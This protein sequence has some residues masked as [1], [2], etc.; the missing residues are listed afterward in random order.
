LDELLVLGNVRKEDFESDDA[1]VVA[2]LLRLEDFPHRAFAELFQESKVAGEDSILVE[3]EARA[4][5]GR[6]EHRL[7]RNRRRWLPG[8]DARG[9]EL[10]PAGIAFVRR[11]RVARHLRILCERVLRR[12]AV[13]RFPVGRRGWLLLIHDGD[14][15]DCEPGSSPLTYSFSSITSISRTS[16]Q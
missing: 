11:D 9:A 3:I 2:N 7:G 10:V 13:Q 8:R 6:D 1:I 12:L 4:Q 14:G 16:C 5:G 15:A